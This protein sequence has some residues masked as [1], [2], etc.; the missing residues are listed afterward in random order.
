MDRGIS[1]RK[2]KKQVQILHWSNS[3]LPFLSTYFGIACAIINAYSP[4]LFSDSA[5]YEAV[6]ENAMRWINQ[7]NELQIRIVTSGI[8]KKRSQWT[9]A[10]A[11]AVPRFLKLTIENINDIILGSYQ[12]KM[13]Q[14]YTH[15]HLSPDSNYSGPRLM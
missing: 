12:I 5:L 9:K 6:V 8:D 1:Q 11:T 10:D 15:Q 7:E 2:N 13:A 14:L 3:H 4:P